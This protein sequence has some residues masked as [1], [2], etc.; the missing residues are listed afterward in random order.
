MF[1]RG[2][3][4]CG[5][6]TIAPGKGPQDRTSELAR[7]FDGDLVVVGQNFVPSITVTPGMV[8]TFRSTSC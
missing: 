4:G 3:R 8:K 6:E 7:L 2:F 1:F 5:L